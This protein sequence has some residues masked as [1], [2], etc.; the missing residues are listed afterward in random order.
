MAVRDDQEKR[1][2][3]SGFQERQNTGGLVAGIHE[4]A[5]PFARKYVGVLADGTYTEPLYHGTLT[6]SS[7]SGAGQA[8]LIPL[9]ATLAVA[10]LFYLVI[11]VAS[12]VGVA[13]GWRRFRRRIV[14]IS[15]L[16]QLGYR[17]LAEAMNGADMGPAG[18]FRLCGKIEAME[19]KERIW[20]RGEHASALVDLSGSPLYVVS[21]GKPEPGAV[22]RFAWKSISSLAAG[23]TIL[24]A[25]RL[26]GERGKPVF[27]DM[28]EERLVAV[29]Y[30]GGEADLVRRLV[31]GGRRTNEYW[32]GLG[33]LSLAVGMTIS[34][35]L[36]VL[37]G[38]HTAFSTVRALSFL[39][40]IL[41]VLPLLPPGLALFLTYRALW[42]RALQHRT[43][44]DLLRLPPGI[45]G[46]AEVGRSDFERLA[47][48]EQSRANALTFLSLLCCA[49]GVLLN[50]VVA[51]LVW[52]G[53]R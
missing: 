7:C 41:P 15:Q 21:P 34:S 18:A 12:A 17:E 28:P 10:L 49:L 32:T 44:R 31:V 4:D 25:G 47:R 11:P 13:C 40:A 36:L 27:V 39:A 52:R 14:E 35:G 53:I 38:S 37:L 48:K 8:V 1:R 5:A 26:R 3:R 43:Q 22:G 19:G 50:Y 29:T 51:F 45:D 20:V 2:A 9:Y 42:R 46:A 16:P 23:T 33:P 6:L 24:V 30:D